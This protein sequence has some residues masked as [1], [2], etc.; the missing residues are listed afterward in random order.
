[1]QEHNRI[2]VLIYGLGSIGKKHIAVLN[3]LSHRQ[4]DI[5]A[6]RSKQP[7]ESVEGVKNIY[8]ENELANKPDFIIIADPTFLRTN[9]ITRAIQF[10][11]PLL[12]EKPPLFNWEDAE[13][14]ARLIDEKNILTY[15]AC[16][17]R[18]HP[19]LQYLQRQLQEARS[20]I[21]EVN[22]YCGSYLP[23]WRG[24]TNDYRKDYSANVEM[25]GGVHLDLYHE[26]DYCYWL[27]GE[28]VSVFS[29]KTNSS[30]L[31]IRCYYSIC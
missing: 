25:G 18:F 21:E 7:A 26:L 4:I 14:I 30:H 2:N 28:P 24:I 22:I 16:N 31:K 27:F 12:I 6:L 13:L 9:T 8:H 3:E 19:C 11:R 15:I 5:Y 20:K 10:G 29:V 1:M 23:E 17:L